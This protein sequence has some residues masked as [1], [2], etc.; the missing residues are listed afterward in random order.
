MEQQE[1]Q[2][3]IRLKL[4]G[5]WKKT[6][7]NSTFLVGSYSPMTDLII[8]PNNHKQK[9]NEPDYHAYIV[10]KKPKEKPVVNGN[11]SFMQGSAPQ[12]Q[13]QPLVPASPAPAPM[14]PVSPPQQP[15]QQTQ[16]QIAQSPNPPMFAQYT[17]TPE[18][19]AQTQQQQRTIDDIPF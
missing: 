15:P 1:Q 11:D 17:P 12:Q 8:F 10:Q 9:E 2:K 6:G 14:P 3:Q 5:L 4:G 18:Q 7:P 13:Q 16:A 19:P